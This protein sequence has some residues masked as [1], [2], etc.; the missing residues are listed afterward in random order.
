MLRHL[1][2]FVQDASASL[3][4]LVPSYTAVYLIWLILIY[5]GST[6]SYV[7]LDQPVVFRHLLSANFQSD[8]IPDHLE[9]S[10]FLIESMLGE[11]EML[12]SCK[13]RENRLELSFSI[14]KQFQ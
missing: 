4:I 14:K 7:V 9:L 6:R 10:F 5:L 8:V 2:A 13:Y 3:F 11:G 12:F 1:G